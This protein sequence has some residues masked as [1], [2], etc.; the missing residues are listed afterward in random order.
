MNGT[1][2]TNYMNYLH[3]YKQSGRAQLDH[4]A[5]KEQTISYILVMNR[6]K[7]F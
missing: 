6:Y 3:I 7:G 1:R 4:Y 2:G 5:C